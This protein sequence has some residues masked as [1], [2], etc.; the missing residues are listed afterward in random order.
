MSTKK[1]NDKNI[2]E[3][4]IDIGL[5]MYGNGYSYPIDLV[6]LITEYCRQ[7][8][9]HYFV[10][11]NQLINNNRISF[12]H[13]LV[14]SSRHKKDSLKR[15][16]QFLQAKDRSISQQDQFI[17]N[18]VKDKK[19]SINDRFRRICHQFQI[20][21]NNN[22]VNQLYNRIKNLLFFFFD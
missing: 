22:Q 4:V 6:D 16:E 10:K 19:I 1:I 20:D 9:R 8:I 13:T 17:E 11:H 12:L 15:L 18:I 21:I 7:Q 3:N 14:Y 2:F 5:R